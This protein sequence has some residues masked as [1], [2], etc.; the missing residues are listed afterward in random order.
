[1]YRHFRCL[2]EYGTNFASAADLENYAAYMICFCRLY[3]V[4]WYTIEMQRTDSDLVAWKKEVFEYVNDENN[5]DT[6][7]QR[8]FL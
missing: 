7:L 3:W 8:L 1:M 5:K 4:A 6:P 2:K